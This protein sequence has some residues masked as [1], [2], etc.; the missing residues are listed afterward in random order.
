LGGGPG[1][2]ACRRAGWLPRLV[3]GDPGQRVPADWD[4]AVSA[5]GEERLF[6]KDKE[7]TDFQLALQELA[8]I[9]PRP[10]VLLTGAFGGRLDHLWSLMH[11][12]L[13]G[14]A[15]TPLG[16]AD[17]E[18]G[19]YLLP[20]RGKWRS[21][22]VT[23]SPRRS[24]SAPPGRLR[25]VGISGVRWPLVD[26]HLALSHPYAVSNRLEGEKGD[27]VRRSEGEPW[28][29]TGA[30]PE[31]D[32]EEG[33]ERGRL[34]DGPANLTGTK[35]FGADVKPFRLAAPHVDSDALKVD[36]P[37]T[38]SMADR[39]ADRVPRL[40]TSTAAIANPGHVIPPLLAAT[41]QPTHCNMVRRRSQPQAF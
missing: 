5:G 39:M 25:R 9:D 19:L 30:S 6:C 7:A 21:G 1:V 15:W 32:G 23:P 4:W 40:G 41:I 34:S 3:L 11:S 18:E 26:T 28:E 20:D 35:T 10:Q 14:T 24:P 2:E 38:T 8:E 33:K 29:S 22:S 31:R 16:M 27:F 12:F 37:A 17:Q 13:P 36:Q